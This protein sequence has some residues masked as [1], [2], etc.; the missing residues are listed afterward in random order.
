MLISKAAGTG[1]VPNARTHNQMPCTASNRVVR[2]V[3]VPIW[4]RGHATRTA[5]HSGR[6][7]RQTDRLPQLSRPSLWQ[8]LSLI[9]RLT[10]LGNERIFADE[11]PAK[12]GAPPP[13]AARE[14]PIV[15]LEHGR[16][17]R[18]IHGEGQPG[19][20]GKAPWNSRATGRRVAYDRIPR[21]C[22]H[23]GRLRRLWGGSWALS[24]RARLPG[25]GA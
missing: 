16:T 10:L 12:P 18:K 20:P 25:G 23:R 4:L 11:N 17:A 3:S 22:H 21:D 7:T 13:R 14:E 8:Q 6:L 5:A 9:A 1:S 19:K 24:S 2:G 15:T